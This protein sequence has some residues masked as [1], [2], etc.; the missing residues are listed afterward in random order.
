MIA[1][2]RRASPRKRPPAPACWVTAVATAA[3]GQARCVGRSSDLWTWGVPAYWASLPGV[4][5]SAFDAGRF[6]LPL[7]GSS[8]L[9]PDSLLSRPDDRIEAGTN[10]HK[11]LWF[12]RLVN[13]ACTDTSESIYSAGIGPNRACNSPACKSKCSCRPNAC[14]IART[15]ANPSPACWG[16]PSR[17]PRQWRSPKWLTSSSRK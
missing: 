3:T 16:S 4:A 10:Q 6:H 7:R 8:G 1:R 13:T 17:C 15:K 14:A 2:T 11:I 12:S 9:A 5:P